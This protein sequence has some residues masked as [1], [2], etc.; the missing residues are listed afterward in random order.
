MK[1]RI[2]V[3]TFA[4]DAKEVIKACG[5]NVEFNHICI[6]D[7]LDEENIEETIFEMKK[8]WKDCEAQSAVIHGPF[9][10]IIPAGI[11]HRMVEAGL[12]RLNEAYEVCKELGVNRMVVHTGFVPLM[13]H[14]VWHLEKSADFWKKFLEDK[15]ED[16]NLLIENVFEDE[17]YMMKDLIDMINDPRAEICLDIGHAN[18]M[19]GE[20]MDVEQWIEVLG[21]RISHVHIHN[22][23]G[24][25]DEHNHIDCGSLCWKTVLK[26][27]EQYAKEDFTVTIECR[28]AKGNTELLAENWK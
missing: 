15:S 12:E 25:S 20:D 8:Y 17:P 26:K 10:E 13:Y 28:D 6:S 27:L 3:A 16:F 4:E 19:S 21:R 7:C 2:Y 5:V 22:N 11:D 9:T 18:A 14:K 24:F 1:D 23:N